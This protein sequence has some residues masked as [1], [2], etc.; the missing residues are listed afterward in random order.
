MTSIRHDSPVGPLRIVAE[1]DAVTGVYFMHGRHAA[2]DHDADRDPTAREREVL[3]LAC[4][5]LDEY[6][7]G[8]RRAFD[9]PL[10]PRGTDFQQR[11]WEQL[12][13]IPYGQTISYGELAR[14]VG[15]TNA[16]RAVGAANGK[17]PVSIIVP[18]HRVIGADGSL[19][20]FGG[21][22]EAKRALIALEQQHATL[23]ATA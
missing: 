4:Q 14:R 19:T 8:D 5:Q 21:G 2:V 23:F 20:G 17:N 3:A 10:A 22:V 11:V 18:C 7:A 13:R 16:S 9:L 6:F 12:T 15:D 1:R